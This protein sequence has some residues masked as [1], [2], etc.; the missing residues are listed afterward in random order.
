MS[1]SG[2]P[3]SMWHKMCAFHHGGN[4]LNYGSDILSRLKFM[5]MLAGVKMIHSLF[6]ND[7]I[8]VPYLQ[9]VRMFSTG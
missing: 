7:P 2:I 1:L 8:Q 5:S 4:G 9:V 3:H 6:P